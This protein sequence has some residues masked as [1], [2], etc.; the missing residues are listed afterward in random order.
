M[1]SARRV[2]TP[3]AIAQLLA[4]IVPKAGNGMLAVCENTGSRPGLGRNGGIE[5]A[6][7]PSTHVCDGA[8]QSSVVHRA[9][10][11]ARD[12]QNLGDLWDSA[13]FDLCSSESRAMATPENAE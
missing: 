6:R 9:T 13:W 10:C 12:L 5:C 2:S 8:P 7:L 1:A 3:P 4:V 11:R